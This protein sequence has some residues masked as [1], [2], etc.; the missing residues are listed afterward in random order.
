M[1]TI[2]RPE[3][4]TI[5]LEEKFHFIKSKEELKNV[6]EGVKEE[7]LLLWGRLID[8]D[9]F[10]PLVAFI[11]LKQG[12]SISESYKYISCFDWGL[13]KMNGNQIEIIE[14]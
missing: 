12:N 14:D 2:Q 1:K 6:L 13:L 3:S 11:I 7:E 4:T 8:V 10:Q 9:S 5:I